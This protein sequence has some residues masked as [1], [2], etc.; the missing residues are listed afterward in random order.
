MIDRGDLSPIGRAEGQPR[1][2]II[3][4]LEGM[5]ESAGGCLPESYRRVIAGRG[6]PVSVRAV[7][8]GADVARMPG[9]RQDLARGRLRDV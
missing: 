1:D 7:L 8:H 4:S 9:E 5:H 2:G 3:V 6:D